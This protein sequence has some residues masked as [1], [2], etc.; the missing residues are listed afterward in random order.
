MLREWSQELQMESDHHLYKGCYIVIS[1]I[2]SVADRIRNI[3]NAF[4]LFY[5]LLIEA[6]ELTTLYI[7]C[8]VKFNFLLNSIFFLF[9][10]FPLHQNQMKLTD[11]LI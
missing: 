10:F 6:N 4:G 1:C 2:G 5:F 7:N 8:R 11:Q 9:T 3:V